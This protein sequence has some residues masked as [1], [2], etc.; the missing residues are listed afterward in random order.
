[1][2]PLYH[3]NVKLWTLYCMMKSYPHCFPLGLSA[4]TQAKPQWTACQHWPVFHQ[5]FWS[6]EEAL[7]MQERKRKARWEGVE[8]TKSNS[9]TSYIRLRNTLTESQGHSIERTHTH[10][11][12]RRDSPNNEAEPM[13]DLPAMTM[14]PFVPHR[15]CVKTA[16]IQDVLHNSFNDIIHS[17]REGHEPGVNEKGKKVLSRQKW[18]MYRW[19]WESGC[20]KRREIR[21]SFQSQSRTI[22]QQ[23]KQDVGL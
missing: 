19:R 2:R 6:Y 8:S 4:I 20:E 13:Q 5:G 22:H 3:I 10:R 21:N 12:Y 1:M 16:E 7:G 9:D 14:Q 11:R 18:T 23:L 17:E 15:D